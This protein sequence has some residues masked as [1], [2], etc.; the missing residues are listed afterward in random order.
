MHLLFTPPYVELSRVGLLGLIGKRPDSTNPT[1][2]DRTGLMWY[3]AGCLVRSNTDGGGPTHDYTWSVSRTPS[4]Q[5]SPPKR[6]RGGI[7]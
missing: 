1:L 6:G 5:P 2:R 4:P 7:E 3:D